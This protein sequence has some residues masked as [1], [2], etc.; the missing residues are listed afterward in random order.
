MTLPY[1]ISST[2]DEMS[3]TLAAR[4]VEAIAAAAADGRNLLVGVPA[5]RTLTPRH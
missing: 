1:S 3:A 2:V 5:G 4:L